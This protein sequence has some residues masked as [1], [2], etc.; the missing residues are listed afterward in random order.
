MAFVD[1]WT[2]DFYKFPGQISKPH[3]LRAE[4]RYYYRAYLADSGGAYDFKM[5]LFVGSTKHTEKT[6]HAARNEKQRI[7]VKA[8]VVPNIQVINVQIF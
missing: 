5:G 6:F 3:Y 2:R 1:A 8:D 4:R 7:T